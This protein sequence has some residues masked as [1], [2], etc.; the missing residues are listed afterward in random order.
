MDAVRAGATS[1]SRAGATGFVRVVLLAALSAA[2]VPAVPRPGAAQAPSN[3][4]LAP[5]RAATVIGVISGGID[6]TYA[7]IAADLMTVLDD[8]ERMRVLPVLGRGSVQNAA[9]ILDLRG[10]DVGIV[11]SDVLAYLRRA[12]LLP[13]VE[14]R[15]H[16][17]TKL[18]D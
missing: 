12:R 17:I 9:D 18:Y 5:A 7:R 16:Y 14:R 6:G 2:A 1:L 8:G 3:P 4:V 11:Q 15:L 13:G 10:V